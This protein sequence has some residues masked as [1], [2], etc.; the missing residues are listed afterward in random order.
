MDVRF[1]LV[2]VNTEE[3]D[4]Q[5]RRRESVQL[6]EKTPSP[7]KRLA[8]PRAR[9]PHTSVPVAPRPRQ[10]ELSSE[11]LISTMLVSARW[12]LCAPSHN[13]LTPR[14]YLL[15]PVVSGEVSAQIFQPHFNWVQLSFVDLGD[16]SDMALQASCPLVASL[17][18][19]IVEPRAEQTCLILIKANL[20]FFFLSWIILLVLH[21]KTHP[22]IRGHLYFPLFSPPGVY[23]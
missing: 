4:F 7:P 23:I 8:V 5:I 14:V 21:L 17:P 9:Q 22:Q 18:G 1:Q 16:S 11:P 20:L 2:G 12:R 6:P 13:S 3:H 15:L 19:L 10:H